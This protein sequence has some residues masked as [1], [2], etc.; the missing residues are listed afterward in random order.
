[1][2]KVGF[3]GA[4]SVSRNHRESITEID[5]AELAA[6]FDL[7]RQSSRKFAEISGA[8]DCE[9]ADEVIE[10]SDA[11]YILTPPHT[12]KGLVLQALDAGKHVMCEKPLAVSLEDGREIAEAAQ[13]SSAHF[14][15]AFS[16]RFRDSY[17]RMRDIYRSG[18]LGE[19][20]TF[21]Y[22]RMFGGGSYNPNNWRYHPDSR[23]GMSI[24]SLSHQIDLI[25]WSV[26]EIESVDARAIASHKELPDVDNNIHV[27]LGLENGC[28]ATIHLSW[29]SYIE[30]NTTGINGTE[31]SL[32]IN[33][34]GGANHDEMLVRFRDTELETIPLN[35]SYDKEI[36]KAESQHFLDCIRSG[37]EPQCSALDGLNALQVSHAILE[38]SRDNRH[39]TL[40]GAR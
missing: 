11:V 25:R 17:R 35:E 23:C 37:E 24:E 1:M 5:G 32:R 27:I 38:S 3:I 29:S 7:N 14:M 31:G 2:I 33:G 16:M 9:S 40:A 20:I 30:L 18:R 10:K 34:T 39:V 6:V 19:A 4:G 28:A 26:S 36:F 22:Q 21:Y 12:H 15:I 13:R 8:E